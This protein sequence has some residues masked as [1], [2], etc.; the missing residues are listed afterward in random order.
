M[1]EKLIP[2]SSQ[3]VGPFFLI[4]L[5][6]LIELTPVSRSGAENVEIHGRILDRDGIPVPDAVLEFW[7]SSEAGSQP[8]GDPDGNA[9]PCGFR[10]ASTDREGRFSALIAH[11]QPISPEDGQKRAP[12]LFVLIFMR[13]L[14]RH[15]I[16]RIYLPDDSSNASD[17][18]L[19]DVPPERRRTLIARADGVASYEWNVILQ[20]NGETVFFA[21]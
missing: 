13:G 12:H 16:S 5:Q 1:T 2:T 14:L 20:G 17:P 6:P 9:Y 4:G 10:R 21:W 18:V 8:A 3:T 15:L 19:Q 11:P 7:C